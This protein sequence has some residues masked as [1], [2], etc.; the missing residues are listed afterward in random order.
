[1][2]EQYEWEDYFNEYKKDL[3]NLSNQIEKTDN[4]INQMV[5][6]LYGLTTEEIQIIEASLK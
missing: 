2:K 6:K 1:M 4:E 3:L 5:Y